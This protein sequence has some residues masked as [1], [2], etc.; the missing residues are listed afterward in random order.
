MRIEELEAELPSL[1]LAVR[2]LARRHKGDE[3]H[4]SVWEWCKDD[5]GDYTDTKKASLDPY[6]MSGFQK[7]L[8]GGSYKSKAEDCR[9]ARRK[10][11]VPGN[12]GAGNNDFGFRIVL[13]ID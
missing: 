10:S 11:S 7:V 4:G 2:A 12:N 1:R 13:V 5:Y 6:K 3:V 8:R 9:S